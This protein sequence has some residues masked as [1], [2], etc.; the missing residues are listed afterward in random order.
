[1]SID[2]GV[3]QQFLSPPL[4]L[5]H[6]VKLGTFSDTDGVQGYINPTTFGFAWELLSWPAGYAAIELAGQR[7]FWNPVF[8]WT[9][10]PATLTSIGGGKQLHVDL[11]D[12][13]EAEGIRMFTDVPTHQL[14]IA[15]SPGITLDLY[16][17]KLI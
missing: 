15:I 10:I 4:Q 12:E 14:A 1:M 7:R 2:I 13:H 5:L 3:I 8:R 16:L 11:V 6:L 17:V 9:Q